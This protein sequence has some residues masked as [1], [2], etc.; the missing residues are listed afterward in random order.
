MIKTFQTAILERFMTKEQIESLYEEY[1]EKLQIVR[2]ERLVTPEDKLI[3]K[4]YWGG[5][6]YIELANKYGHS[7]NKIRNSIRIAAL[8]KLRNS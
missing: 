4:D 8:D 5:M 2:R 3:F 1:K 7:P 6:S